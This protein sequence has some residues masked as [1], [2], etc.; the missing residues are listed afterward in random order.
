MA[1]WEVGLIFLASI[2]VVWLLL[3]G[4]TWI[5]RLLKQRGAPGHPTGSPDPY[6]SQDP[7]SSPGRWPD[8]TG[9]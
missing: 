5:V 1:N 7:S 4:G 6:P 2:V 9:R 3:A 8:D